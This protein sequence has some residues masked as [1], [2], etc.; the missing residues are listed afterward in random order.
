[1]TEKEKTNISRS[2][3]QNYSWKV[4]QRDLSAV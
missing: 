2:R 3:K 4:L 1:V